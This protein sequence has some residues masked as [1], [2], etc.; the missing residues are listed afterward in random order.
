[1]RH[2]FLS[3]FTAIWVCAAG[4]AFVSSPAPAAD[5]TPEYRLADRTLVAALAKGDRQAT[6]SL[7]DENFQWVEANGKS[8]TKAQVLEDVAAFASDNENPI[9][10]RTLDLLGQVERV[11]GMHHN[12]RFAQIWVKRPSGW[13]AFLF[14][15]IPIPAEPS[16]NLAPPKPPVDSDKV[17]ENPCKTLPYKQENAAQGGSLR[18]S[19]ADFSGTVSISTGAGGD[20]YS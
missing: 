19:A 8:H 20:K 16:K 15:D 14:V 17:C 4:F 3:I 13:Q 11:L 9:D 6:A 12:Q 1:M 5:D 7:L 2:S 10:V 18:I